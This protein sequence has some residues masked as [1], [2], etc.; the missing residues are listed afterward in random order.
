MIKKITLITIMAFVL[1]GGLS[2][3]EPV[4]QKPLYIG[5]SFNDVKTILGLDLMDSN[6]FE[7]DNFVFILNFENNHTLVAHRK[8]NYMFIGVDIYSAYYITFNMNSDD[9][10]YWS[11]YEV[12]RVDRD[13]PVYLLFKE[14]ITEWIN[15]LKD[16]CLENK[17]IKYI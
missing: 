3:S 11:V 17:E 6:V 7:T 10:E 9:T 5:K 15:Y 13:N 2:H 16:K 1:I 4:G 8:S 12:S 14:M